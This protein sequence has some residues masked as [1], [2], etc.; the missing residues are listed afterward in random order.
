VAA[1][2]TL[3]KI[4]APPASTRTPRVALPKRWAIFAIRLTSFTDWAAPSV[5]TVAR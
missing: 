5:C 1:V 4:S 3:A 2:I